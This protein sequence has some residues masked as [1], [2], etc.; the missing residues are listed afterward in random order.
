MYLPGCRYTQNFIRME[1][2]LVDNKEK[3]QFE[4]NMDD[5]KV[6]MEYIE[7]ADKIFLTHTEVPIG[8][9]GKGYGSAIIKLALE[10]VEARQKSLMPL[11]PF[12]VP[13]IKRHTE[14]NRLLLGNIKIE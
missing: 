3:K 6:V 10:G 7:T 4:L 12:V 5:P 1:Y 11:C 14:W 8:H 2:Q 13:Y 9:E